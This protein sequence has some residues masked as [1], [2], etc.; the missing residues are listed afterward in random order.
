MYFIIEIQI[1]KAT[2]LVTVHMFEA[3]KRRAKRIQMI[4]G[5]AAATLPISS[6]VCIIFLILACN[7]KN[8]SI[9]LS[10]IYCV[11]KSLLGKNFFKK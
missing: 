1:T 8:K 10:A 7:H 9:P 6:S 4:T 5:T 2:K 11:F 3:Q